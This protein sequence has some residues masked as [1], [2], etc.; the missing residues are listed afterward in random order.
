M[1]LSP[2]LIVAALVLPS[3][4]QAQSQVTVIHAGRLLDRP[5]SAPRGPSSI[6]VEN[7]RIARIESGFADVPGARV[8]D[9][10]GRFV[11]PGLIDSTFISKA[12]PVG[13]RGLWRTFPIMLR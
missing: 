5:G 8:V 13:P 4:A 1:R 2:L 6:I 7:G 10:R 12:T 9:L 3:A 11:L